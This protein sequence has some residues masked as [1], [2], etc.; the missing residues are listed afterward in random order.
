MNQ[1]FEMDGEYSSQKDNEIG[2]LLLISTDALQKDK[3]QQRL[4]NKQ[5][6]AQWEV[7]GASLVAYKEAL[8]SCKGRLEK[9]EDQDHDFIVRVAEFQR[10]LNT[11]QNRWPMLSKAEMLGLPRQKDRK[12][13]KGSGKQV[14]WNKYTNMAGRL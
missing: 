6:K 12:G 3:E 14:R 11:N 4:N 13:S 2:W 5:L 1:I 8:I 10:W 7:K 9:A